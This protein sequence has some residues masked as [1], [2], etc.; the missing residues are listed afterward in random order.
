MGS[1]G[2]ILTGIL[3]VNALGSIGTLEAG[4]AVGFVAMGMSRADAVATG[5]AVHLVLIVA[6][7]ALAA[8]SLIVV[9]RPTWRAFREWRVRAEV[10]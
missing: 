3:P 6:A 10:S 5:F 7:G 1:V 2:A 4:W 8:L 9:G